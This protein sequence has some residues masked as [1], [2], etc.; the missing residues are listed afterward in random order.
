MEKRKTQQKEA[1]TVSNVDG[2]MSGILSE[3]PISDIQTIIVV[4]YSLM[5]QGQVQNR[6]FLNVTREGV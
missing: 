5:V 3:S 6:K 4:I 1:S 2:L